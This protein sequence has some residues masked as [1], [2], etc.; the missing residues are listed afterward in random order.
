[1]SGVASENSRKRPSTALLTPSA[2]ADIFDFRVVQ[3]AVLGA[4]APHAGFLDAA[5]GSNLGRNYAGI[6][7]DDSVLDRFRNTPTAREIASVNVGGQS[8]LGVVRHDDG[9][10]FGVE[11]EQRGDRT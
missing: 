4:F 7:S 10:R 1:M 3:N 8:E 5:E 11:L 6:Q 2:H 9:L